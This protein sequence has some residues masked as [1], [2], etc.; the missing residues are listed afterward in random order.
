MLTKLAKKEKIYIKGIIL[1]KK[2]ISAFRGEYPRKMKEKIQHTRCRQHTKA[3]IQ[4]TEIQHTR[5]R[6]HTKICIQHTNIL[7]NFWCEEGASCNNSSKQKQT[8][9]CKQD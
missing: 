9:I 7:E 1:A 2:E 6:Q 4:H 5:C 3:C 8:Q